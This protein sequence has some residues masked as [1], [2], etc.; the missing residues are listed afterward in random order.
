MSETVLLRFL[1]SGL[2]D[3]GGDDAKLAKLQAT[4]AEVAGLLK[5][6]PAKTPN[7]SLIAFDPQ[8]PSSDPTILEVLEVLKKQWPTYV[9]TFASTPVGVL[10]PLI[11]DA[12][13]EAS[14][15]DDRVAVAFVACARNVLPFMETGNE[16]AI[17]ADVVEKIE[18]DVDHRAEQEWATPANISIGQLALQSPAQLKVS[19]GSGKVDKDALLAKLIAGAG[20]NPVSNPHWPQNNPTAWAQSLGTQF[21]EAI[22]EAIDNAVAQNKVASI[23]LSATMQQITSA[24][25]G[26]VSD[27]IGSVDGATA[28]LQRRTNLIWWKQALFSPSTRK[29]YRSFEPTIAAALM[30]LDLYQQIPMFSPAS[31]SA[32][33]EEAVRS[34]QTSVPN[35]GRMLKDLLRVTTENSSLA[36]LRD[37]A[38]KLYHSPSGRCPISA[39]IGHPEK[40]IGLSDGGLVNLIGIETETSLTDAQWASWIFRDLQAGRATKEQPKKRNGKGAA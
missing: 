2:I 35:S 36:P 19:S 24:V 28:G 17:W 4:A 1:S 37:E 14:H 30:A 15:D 34:L 31:V 40:I 6:H 32:F 21:A 38:A 20:G 13:A 12:L 25:S 11:L 23:D 33:L 5:K 29:S 16:Q 10:R 26:Y 3:V 8:A 22:S 39:L 18:S 9:N 7:Y 27:V